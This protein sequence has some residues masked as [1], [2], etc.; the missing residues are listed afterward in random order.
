MKHDSCEFKW[1]NSIWFEI[2]KID[3]QFKWEL[4]S[5][6]GVYKRV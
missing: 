4:N 2:L 3:W 5:N 1:F 6:A